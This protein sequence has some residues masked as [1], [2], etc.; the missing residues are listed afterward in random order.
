MLKFGRDKMKEE[1]TLSTVYDQELIRAYASF[2]RFKGKYYKL[3]RNYTTVVTILL[4]TVLVCLII[5]GLVSKLLDNGEH[6]QIGPLFVIAMTILL[7][8][9]IDYQSVTK[10]NR[11]LL[12]TSNYSVFSED[13][14]LWYSQCLS[15]GEK[16]NIKY[17]EIQTLY[18]CKGRMYLFVN[19][20][21]AYLID[22][23]QVNGETL[24]QLRELLHRKLQNEKYVIYKE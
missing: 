3:R 14:I 4:L 22:T 15:V 5:L 18:E 2:S 13:G 17:E 11:K 12:Y 7:V 20:S 8:Q 10:C 19:K 16:V 21:Q 6:H 9:G 23:T 1:I 24:E